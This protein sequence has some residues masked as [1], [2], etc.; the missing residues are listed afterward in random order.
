MAVAD[1]SKEI[2]LIQK[3]N[4]LIENVTAIPPFTGEDNSCSFSEFLEKFENLAEFFVWSEEEKKF[5]LLSRVG[6]SAARLYKLNKNKTVEEIVKIFK[7]RYTRQVTP[8]VALANFLSFKQPPNMSVQD[9]YDR[10]FDLSIKALCV[11]GLEANVVSQSRTALLHSMLLGNL[12]PEIR[13]GVIT[14]NPKTPEEILAYA[15][16]EEK[17]CRSINPFFNM[18]VETVAPFIPQSVQQNLACA[19]IQPPREIDQL[20]NQVESLTKKIDSLLAVSDRQR[21]RQQQDRRQSRNFSCY[22]CSR[23]DHIAKYC[24]Q[25]YYQYNYNRGRNDNFR[26]RGRYNNS[27]NSYGFR[28]NYRGNRGRGNQSNGSNNREEQHAENR[29]EMQNNPSTQNPST[30]PLN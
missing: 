28:G 3:K 18:Q 12:A 17:A 27:Q 26:G 2:A 1:H 4:A 10:A 21:D 9:F 13:K 29:T 7:D 6:G 19:A 20:K 15:L 23:E 5:A 24:P 16:L 8:D 14:K 25:N 22:I 30:D 11:E